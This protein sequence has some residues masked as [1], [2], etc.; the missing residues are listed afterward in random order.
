MPYTRS[1]AVRDP[2]PGRTRAPA[3]GRTRAPAPGRARG[4]RCWPLPG[5]YCAPPSSSQR[6][7]AAMSVSVTSGSFRPVRRSS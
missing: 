3:P 4:V 6:F 5:P 7:S 2:A 1:G